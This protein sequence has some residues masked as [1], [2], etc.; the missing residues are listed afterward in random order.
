MYYYN[1]NVYFD[2]NITV[3]ADYFNASDFNEF[4]VK[5]GGRD[6][7]A[8]YNDFK[9]AIAYCDGYNSA[10]TNYDDWIESD[11]AKVVF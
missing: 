4:I 10:V 7:L 8:K 11:L 9:L 3:K 2:N 6:N 5:T 1:G